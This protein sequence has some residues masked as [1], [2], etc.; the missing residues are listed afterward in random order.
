MNLVSATVIVVPSFA[1]LSRVYSR[2]KE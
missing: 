1:F 2:I